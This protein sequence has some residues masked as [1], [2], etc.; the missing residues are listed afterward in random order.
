MRNFRLNYSILLLFF[1]IVLISCD[2]TKKYDEEEQAKID[3]FLAINPTLV[4][5]RK[6]SG[7]YYRDI[8]VGTGAQVETHDTVYIFFTA[9]LLDGLMFDSNLNTDSI[10]FV[11]NEGQGMPALNEGLQYMKEG[12][13]SAMLVPSDLAFGEMG[14][15]YVGNLGAI[16]IGGYTPIL[17]EVEVPTLIKASGR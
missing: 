17:L 1:V 13:K 8:T 15:T 6:A 10:K 14:T 9:K 3:N 11:V 2:K 7:L 12:G 4:F 16:V 5:E